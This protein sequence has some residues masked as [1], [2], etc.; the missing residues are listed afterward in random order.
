MTSSTAATAAVGSCAGIST[1]KLLFD[2]LTWCCANA[3]NVAQF[4]SFVDDSGLDLTKVDPA[5]ISK[6]IEPMA[7]LSP[8]RLLDVYR[9]QSIKW[10]PSGAAAATM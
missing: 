6:F 9:S 1:T 2:L 10:Y 7:A 3:G 5:V 4:N 8:A